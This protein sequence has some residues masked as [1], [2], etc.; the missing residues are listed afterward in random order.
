MARFDGPMRFPTTSRSVRLL[1]TAI[2]NIF[3]L[4]YFIQ[5]VSGTWACV[6]SKLLSNPTLSRS[7]L[8]RAC[9]ACKHPQGPDLG[10]DDRGAEVIPI[11]MGA[12]QS[13]Q[14]DSSVGDREDFGIYAELRESDKSRTS[15]SYI[16]TL[17]CH[18]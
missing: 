1:R 12:P 5:C 13:G 18:A 10:K 8:N 4:I 16:G 9:L 3:N 7:C 2:T 17:R 15:L 14:L 11:V 6:T